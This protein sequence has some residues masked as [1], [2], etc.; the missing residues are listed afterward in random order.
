MAISSTAV[1]EVRPTGLSQNGGMFNTAS[2]GV[3]YSQQDV[4]QLTVTDL[5]AN[6]TTTLTSVQG[7]FTP[8]MVG[9]GIFGTPNNFQAEIVQV[10]NSN[11]I[12]V[13]AVVVAATR[14]GR[15]GGAKRYI[16]NAGQ[17]ATAGNTIWTKYGDYPT[18]ISSGSNTDGGRLNV[19]AANLKV[20]GYD[21]VRGDLT[22]N[23]P[24]IIATVGHATNAAINIGGNYSTL[25]NF[26][27]QM[28]A[29]TGNGATV[30]G[31][32]SRTEYCTVS[33]TAYSL[34]INSSS[35][36]KCSGSGGGPLNSVFQST[37]S[38]NYCISLNA[39]LQGMVIIGDGATLTN[40]IAMYSRN[41]GFL[42]A[43][44][45]H[46]NKC[47]AYGNGVVASSG[48]FSLPP[49]RQVNIKDCIAYGNNGYGYDIP[50]SDVNSRLEN[51]ASGNNV[52]GDYQTARIGADRVTGF[53]SLT[54]NPFKDPST[55]SPILTNKALLDL[56]AAGFDIPSSWMQSIVIPPAIGSSFI[57][58]R[59]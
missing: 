6:G 37:G 24:K 13:D 45:S 23:K 18:D 21:L 7:G 35:L 51:C 42:V 59:P 17:Y 26:E 57:P 4:A 49:S 14:T 52:L 39:G 56:Y 1:W 8:Q 55:G 9:N 33:G 47:I 44:A 12:V 50:A 34:G 43:A 25:S 48:G 16:G 40:S 2:A 15:V 22:G 5:I 46:V 10:V 54:S 3:D 53:L 32:A 11:T 31:A 19:S 28:G 41:Y 38:I 30:L 27:F 20:R 58:F 29:F 36:Y